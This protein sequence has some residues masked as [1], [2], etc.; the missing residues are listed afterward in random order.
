[1]KK[2]IT[3]DEELQLHGLRALAAAANNQLREIKKVAKRILGV[4]ADDEAREF[5]TGIGHIDDFAGSAGDGGEYD[6]GVE[7]LLQRLGI[8][9]E[10]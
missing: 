5:E 10:R 6:Y 3:R 4:T 1:M 8:E 2:K 7:G 9:V